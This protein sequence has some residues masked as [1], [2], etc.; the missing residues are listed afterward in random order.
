MLSYISAKF[1]QVP[2]TQSHEPRAALFL[3]RF[4]RTLTIMY[5][6]NGLADVLGISADEFTG[7]SFYYCIQ[8]N[9]LQDAIRCLESAKAN[10]SIAYLRFWFRDPRHDQDNDQDETMSDVH[11]GPDFHG[12]EE[13]EDDGGVHL[14]G[15]HYEEGSENALMSD[16]GSNSRSGG[17]VDYNT[18]RPQYCQPIDPNSRT[19]SGNSTDLDGNANDTIFDQAPTASSSASSLPTSDAGDDRWN[20]R[21]RNQQRPSIQVELEAVVSCTSDGLVVIL[22]RARPF[23]PPIVHPTQRRVPQ[24]YANGLFASPWA[25]EPIMPEFHQH[26]QY[27]ENNHQSSGTS[28]VRSF[29]PQSTTTGPQTEDFMN[30]IR[31]VAVFAWALT[32]ING[33]LAQYSRGKPTGNAQPPDGLPIWNPDSNDG[34]EAVRPYYGN[35][36]HKLD[37]NAHPSYSHPQPNQQWSGA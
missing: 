37:G 34:P 36:P 2:K 24:T 35:R 21:Q 27:V 18:Q 7:K 5:A 19:S 8:E 14:N 17:S 30:S 10:D 4:T 31:E 6:T 32:G 23:F 25:A 29:A 3:N 15:R 11:D 12:S 16:S 13:D 20:P 9:C 26:P 22:R 33:S 28:P 1:S